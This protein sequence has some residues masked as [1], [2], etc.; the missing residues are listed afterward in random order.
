[1]SI[2]GKVE[3][4]DVAFSTSAGPVLV[5]CRSWQKLLVDRRLELCACLKGLHFLR[6]ITIKT[7]Q[8]AV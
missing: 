8:A 7:V 4:K 1:M 6:A 2:I 3:S 5:I